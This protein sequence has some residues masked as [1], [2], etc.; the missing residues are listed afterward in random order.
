MKV[1]STKDWKTFLIRNKWAPVRLI[2][3]LYPD[4]NPRYDLANWT[5]TPRVKQL[6][7]REY[8]SP[9]LRM[10]DDQAG[11]VLKA[12][13]KYYFEEDLGIDFN[14]ADAAYQLISHSWD[15]RHELY[16][17][18]GTDYL[19]LTKGDH[20][21]WR[22]KGYTNTAF[23]AYHL[24]PGMQWCIKRALM[25]EMFYQSENDKID[26][27][28]VL[29][30]MEIIW[31]RHIQGLNNQASPEE[32]K[33]A[34][35]EFWCRCEEREFIRQKEHWMR[36]GISALLLKRKPGY[37]EWEINLANK[38]GID[39]GLEEETTE[40]GARW[41]TR[42]YREQNPNRS[43]DR[44]EYSNSIPVDLHHL[45]PRKDFPQF[46]Y[47]PENVVALNPQVHSLIT[48]K[49]WS[50]KAGKEYE[51]AIRAWQEAPE[52]QKL[53]VFDNIMRD[54]VLETFT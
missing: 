38:F 54:L 51:G 32:I 31:L 43:L 19:A 2:Q 35:E 15:R 34:K 33:N 20:A 36:W 13:F 47:H 14:D 49:K 29:A 9:S 52:G 12:I 1:N 23:I 17:Y 45:L 16:V 44:C 41:N 6:L 5:K 3:K 25:P 26:D 53:Q 11:E 8:W 27:K 21:A 40:K 42:S 30:M 48:R 10:E 18:T 37:R 46:T 7:N 4:F 50:E 28:T 22:R 39:L 24:Y